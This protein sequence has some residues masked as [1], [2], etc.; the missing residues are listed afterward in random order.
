MNVL[1][2]CVSL[3][4]ACLTLKGHRPAPR[5]S[6]VSGYLTGYVKLIRIQKLQDYRSPKYI[7]I[8]MV[9]YIEIQS[10]VC[11]IGQVARVINSSFSHEFLASFNNS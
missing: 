10:V 1:R 11:S 6:T 3:K 9:K 7:H 8:S 5:F 4:C 2:T